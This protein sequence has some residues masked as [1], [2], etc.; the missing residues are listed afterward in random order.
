MAT[1]R[2]LPRQIA[3]SGQP[4]AAA[5][6]KVLGLYATVAMTAE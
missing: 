1:F 6:S 2:G 3:T 5:L 4:D